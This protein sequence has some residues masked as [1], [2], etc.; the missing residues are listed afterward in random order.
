MGVCDVL[1]IASDKNPC[2]MFQITQTYDFS[3]TEDSIKEMSLT[4]SV[5]LWKNGMMKNKNFHR[6][7]Q[8]NNAVYTSF[9]NAQFCCSRDK[10]F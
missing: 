6:V 7:V 10:G 1:L 3:Y 9:N 2:K 8:S 4:L 5:L